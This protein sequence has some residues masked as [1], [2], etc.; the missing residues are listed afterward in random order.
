MKELQDELRRNYLTG[1]SL[2]VSS[3]IYQDLTVLWPYFEENYAFF[4]TLPRDARIVE[5]GSGS[6]S[7]VSWLASKGFCNLTGL[8]IS[9]Q[10]VERAKQRGLPLVCADAHEYLA[11]QDALSTDVVIAKA[12]FEHMTKQEGADLL[13]SVVRVLK[14]DC[15]MVV[16]DVPNMDWILSNHERYMDLTHHVGYTVDSMSQMLRLY[17]Q[18]VEVHGSME[19]V[20]SLMNFVRVRVVKPVLVKLM[21]AIFRV[22]GEGAANVLFECRSI[23]AVGRVGAKIDGK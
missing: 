13:K 23:I 17:F 5:I 14:P 7:L 18:S 15:G 19:P 16:L 20:G 10:E 21:R 8:D 9:A 6:G 2:H 1:H 22:M 3:S 4:L 12:V 11:E